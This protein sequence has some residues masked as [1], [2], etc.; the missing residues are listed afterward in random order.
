MVKILIELAYLIAQ[1]LQIQLFLIKLSLM[2]EREDAS[3]FVLK[4]LLVIT[5]QEN[6]IQHLNSALLGGVMIIIIV[7]F[8]NAQGLRLGILLEIILQDYVQYFALKDY[9]LIAIQEQDN[10]FLFVQELMIFMVM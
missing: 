1:I 4:Q 3:K 9:M 10:V 5:L 8:I 6:V 2:M 7:V